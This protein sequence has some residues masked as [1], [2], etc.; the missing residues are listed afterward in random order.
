MSC[1]LLLALRALLTVNCPPR[2]VHNHHLI[3]LHNSYSFVFTLVSMFRNRMKGGKK[4]RRKEGKREGRKKRIEERK[5]LNKC[6]VV[7]TSPQLAHI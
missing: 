3:H 5:K 7:H 4:E 1:L 2:I 6:L